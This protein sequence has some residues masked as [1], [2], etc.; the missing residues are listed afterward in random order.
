[1]GSSKSKNLEQRDDLLNSVIGGDQT[2]GTT[3]LARYFALGTSEGLLSDLIDASVTGQGELGQAARDALGPDPVTPVVKRLLLDVVKGAH[4]TRDLVEE[5]E[6][7]LAPDVGAPL[8]EGSEDL[9]RTLLVFGDRATSEK[10]GTAPLNDVLAIPS[11]SIVNSSSPSKATPGLSAFVVKPIGIS[12]GTKNVAALSL[13]MNAV[14]T[15]EFS[16]AV[17]FVELT[18]Q[19][20]RPAISTDGRLSSLSQLKFILGAARVAP[21]SVDERLATATVGRL[22]DAGGLEAVESTTLA[23]M[24]LFLSPQ[25]LVPVDLTDGFGGRV[26]G[27]SRVAPVL[28]PFRP[29]MSLDKLSIEIAAST[30]FMSFKTAKLD[31]T[32]HDRSRLA[33]VAELVKPD[34]F[35]KTELMIEYGWNHPDGHDVDRNPFG[36]LLNA[37]RVREKYG[38]VN[39]SFQFE[40]SGVV[41]ISLQLAMKGANEYRTV[42]VGSDE[43]VQGAL[44]DVAELQD[45][46]AELRDALSRGDARRHTG[47]LLAEQVLESAQTTNG[48]PTITAAQRKKLKAVVTRLE[49]VGAADV[50]LQQLADVVK[51]LYLEG[52]NGEK[53]AVDRLSTSVA[54]VIERRFRALDGLSPT[55]LA[56]N[57]DVVFDDGELGGG[58]G[59]AVDPFIDLSRVTLED[60]QQVGKTSRFVSFGKVFMKF[61]AEPIA[62]TG[63]FDEVQVLFYPMNNSAGAARNRSVASILIEREHLKREFET[64]I[65]DRRA[66]NVT[67][68]EFQNFLNSTFLDNVANPS[69][70]MSTV[71]KA[72]RDVDGTV[73]QMPNY[74]EV[75][76]RDKEVK[77]ATD[78]EQKLLSMGVPDGVFKPPSI[79]LHIEAIPARQSRHQT[80]TDSTLRDSATILR[81]HVFDKVATAYETQGELI[82]SMADSQ[83]GDIGYVETNV[84]GDEGRQVESARRII[85]AADRLGILERI[86]DEQS[87]GGDDSQPSAKHFRIVGGPAALRKFVMSTAPYIIY[88]SQNSAIET[89]GLASIQDPALSTVNMIRTDRAGSMTPEGSGRGGVPLKTIPARLSV[90]SLGCPLLAF[91]QQFFVDAQTGTDLDNIYAIT[92]LSHQIDAT[93]FKSSFEMVPQQAYGK[94]ESTLNKVEQALGVLESLVSNA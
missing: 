81:I 70:G 25:T 64:F 15:L 48:N 54:S 75:R 88:G 23:G 91:M 94:Y 43:L 59:A 24:E 72:K 50:R 49:A 51:E 52:Q 16:R 92:S 36:A 5:L 28:D 85:Q 37:M 11:D 47:G 26:A 79:D 30:G 80:S 78:L 42:Q 65:M 55:S 21:G 22:D 3:G 7:L 90:T 86:P 4:F 60:L 69:Y 56:S 8:V 31:V 41:K 89:L 9:R 68:G 13:F 76:G 18:V 33:E 73:K 35:S 29:L 46:V 82:K 83:L 19:T 39:S 12:P 61:I 6:L 45:R 1:M 17:P 74:S 66:S 84:G 77:W 10:Y 53:S 34:L 32:V 20:P 27:S 93:T 38:I 40:E 2:R 14:P 57:V 44:R 58:G 87:T 67:V 63:R 71:Y 62:T